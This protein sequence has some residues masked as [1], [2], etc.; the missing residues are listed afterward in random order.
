LLQRRPPSG[1][2]ASLWSLPQADDRLAAR[3]WF[4]RHLLGDYEAAEP[5]APIG[6]GFS[7]YRLQLQPLRLHRVAMRA[8]V[9]DNP[10]LRWVAREQLV[11]LGIPAPI[12]K[13][14]QD[15]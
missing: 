8:Q 15:D 6:H 12:R 5:L 7:H 4:D 9:A 10:D 2:W 11:S 14:L 1:V 13:L 3:A